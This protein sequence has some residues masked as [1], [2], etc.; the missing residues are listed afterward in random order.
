MT[1]KMHE[2]WNKGGPVPCTEHEGGTEVFVCDVAIAALRSENERL[3]RG[4]ESIVTMVNDE[5][6]INDEQMTARTLEEIHHT[7]SLLL[8]T[9]KGGKG[10]KEGK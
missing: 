3:R 2:T 10:E 1:C 8:L 5:R 9:A 4:L 7:A 6:L